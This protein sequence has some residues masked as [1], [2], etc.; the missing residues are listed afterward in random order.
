MNYIYFA[1]QEAFE[2]EQKEVRVSSVQ[3][4]T[5]KHTGCEAFP[6][7]SGDAGT[8]RAGLSECSQGS[9]SSGKGWAQPRE[10]KKKKNNT[11]T[12]TPVWWNHYRPRRGNQTGTSLYG[13]LRPEQG[14]EKRTAGKAR[15][16]RGAA[17]GRMAGGGMGADQPHSTTQGQGERAGSVQGTCPDR[18]VPAPS[19]SSTAARATAPDLHSCP[20]KYAASYLGPSPQRSVQY[21]LIKYS[22]AENAAG[23]MIPARRLG[24]VCLCCLRPGCS[25]LAQSGSLQMQIVQIHVQT[26]VKG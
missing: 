10:W 23:V 7:G 6:G 18:A 11:Q 1:A 15:P 12:T 4:G 20:K 2:T 22:L 17:R 19:G 16:E 9:P 5:T 3:S 8:G 13:K 25:T 21:S 14:N 26:N 24:S